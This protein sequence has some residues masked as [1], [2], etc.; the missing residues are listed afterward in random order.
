MEKVKN[1]AEKFTEKL[2]EKYGNKVY[3][4]QFQ[5]YLESG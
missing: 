2:S 3:V 5:I 4:Y 1:E